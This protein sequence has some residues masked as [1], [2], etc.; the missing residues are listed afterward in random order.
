ME[1][2][3]PSIEELYP[4]LVQVKHKGD[5]MGVTLKIMK[6]L[7][8]GILINK[9]FYIDMQ[10]D[11]ERVLVYFRKSK[12]AKTFKAIKKRVRDGEAAE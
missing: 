7:E 6:H 3:L 2:E 5:P 9:D 8:P 12:N 11:P 4:H 1:R 10:G